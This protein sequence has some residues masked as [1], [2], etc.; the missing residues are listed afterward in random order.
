[1]NMLV[2]EELA[3][4]I[5]LVKIDGDRISVDIAHSSVF[6][7]FVPYERRIPFGRALLMLPERHLKQAYQHP[8][9]SNKYRSMASAVSTTRLARTPVKHP[10]VRA[11]LWQ[12]H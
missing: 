12:K 1:M 10:R 4:V 5:A 7:L 2:A 6:M 9:T 3:L 11:V 8:L